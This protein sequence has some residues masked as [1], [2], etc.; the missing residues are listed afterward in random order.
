VNLDV[1]AAGAVPAGAVPL[2]EHPPQSDLTRIDLPDKVLGRPRFI[3]DWN[4][5]AWCMPG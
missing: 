1:D 4:C 3:Q 5:R 2:T